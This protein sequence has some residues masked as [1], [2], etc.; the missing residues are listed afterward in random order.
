MGAGTWAADEWTDGA[1]W[2]ELVSEDDDTSA[3]VRELEEH[4]DDL[5]SEHHD[6]EPVSAAVLVEE[7]ERFLREQ[8]D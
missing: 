8:R 2:Q 6:D 5:E 3:Y 1:G 4:Y 7:V